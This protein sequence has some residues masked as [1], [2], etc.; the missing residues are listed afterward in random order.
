MCAP[1]ATVIGGTSVSSLLAIDLDLKAL[2]EPAAGGTGV[3]ADGPTVEE[4]WHRDAGISNVRIRHPRLVRELASPAGAQVEE[5]DLRRFVPG[6]GWAEVDEH[7]GPAVGTDSP[8]EIPDWWKMRLAGPSRRS[9]LPFALTKKMP[10]SGGSG[11]AAGSSENC[12]VTSKT[13]PEPSGSTAMCW[14]TPIRT[15][16]KPKRLPPN[17]RHSPVGSGAGVEGPTAMTGTG[18]QFPRRMRSFCCSEVRPCGSVVH[19]FTT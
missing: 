3:V 6:R 19:S 12:F 18:S 15:N 1:G 16:Q 17:S 7:D 4:A 2:K 13:T 9:P 10:S 8:P 14:K 11:V 5:K